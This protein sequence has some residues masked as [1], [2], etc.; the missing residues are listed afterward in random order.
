[1][2]ASLLERERSKVVSCRTYVPQINFRAL[3]PFLLLSALAACDLTK[4]NK[5]TIPAAYANHD[6]LAV[7]DSITVDEESTVEANVLAN[8]SDPD[9]SDSL[10]IESLIQPVHGIATITKANRVLYTPDALYSG[11]DSFS[12]DLSDGHGGSSTA[13]V[14]I[15]VNHRNHSPVAHND[16]SSL[17]EDGSVNINVLA[18]DT[19]VDSGDSLNVLSVG[20]PTHGIATLNI[21]NSITYTPNGGFHGEDLFNYTS[22]DDHSGSAI[23][24]VF[25]TVDHVNH[26][27]LAVADTA[28][29]NENS[30]VDVSVLANDTDVDSDTL[31]ILSID[32]QSHGVASIVNTQIH[33]VPTALYFGAATITYTIS[34]GHGGN[35]QASVAI[36]VVPDPTPPSGYAATLTS[37]SLTRK[38]TATVNIT[39]TA[40]AAYWIESP[41]QPDVSAAWQTCP[42]ATVFSGSF[43]L[44]AGMNSP[45]IWFMSHSQIVAASAITLSAV[46]KINSV[47]LV[48][49]T[50]GTGQGYNGSYPAFGTYAVALTNGNIVAGDK[51]D[52]T[53]G[54]N[55]GAWHLYNGTSGA[56]IASYYGAQANDNFGDYG[57]AALSNGNFVLQSYWADVSGVTDSG[58]VMLVNGTSGAIITSFSGNNPNDRFGYDST[59]DLMNGNFVFSSSMDTVAGKASAGSVTLVNGTTG[60][61]LNTASGSN[62]GD[63]MAISGMMING[64]YAV[65]TFNGNS[66]QTF[67]NGTTGTVQ[68][69]Y[70]GATAGDQLGLYGIY[71]L[72]NGNI[73]MLSPVATVAGHANAGSTTLLQQGTYTV[74]ATLNGSHA[75]DYF[76]SNYFDLNNGNFVLQTSYIDVGAATDAGALTL[77][78]GTTGAVISTLSGDNTNDYFGSGGFLL[79]AG[80]NFATWS[81]VDDVAG[82]IDAGSV[83]MINGT[84]GAVITTTTGATAGDKIGSNFGNSMAATLLSNG[85]FVVGSTHKTVGGFINA[86]SV[87]LLNGT[88]GD[89]VAT[90]NGTYQN[91]LLGF[92]GV[93]ALTNGNFVI[94]QEWA[95]NGAI[96]NAGSAILVNG[97]NGDTIATFRG[98]TAEDQ[99]GNDGVVDLKNGNFVISSRYVEKPGI[100]DAG[101]VTLINATSGVI[102]ST[103]VGDGWR[104]M[105]GI[106]GVYRLR[107]GNYVVSTFS[108]DN[109]GTNAGSVIL[110]NGSNGTILNTVHGDHDWDNFGYSAPVELPNGNF[111]F[112][113]K[114]DTVGGVTGVGS[115]TLMSGSTGNVLASFHGSTANDNM[116][117]YLFS[118]LPNSSFVIQS[119]SYDNHGF[120]DAGHLLLVP[121]DSD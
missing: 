46:N 73:L 20:N 2:L 43:A 86:G 77:V 111:I 116:G 61:I 59:W 114:Y 25:V 72:S 64:D 44:L 57:A 6:P 39:C 21:D 10:T 78:N 24:T 50:P 9:N 101:T 84:T 1:M 112:A 45:K 100:Q 105:M 8:D 47:E 98:D 74:I 87:M 80:G 63:A 95:S 38:S 15:I 92:S 89:I 66:S 58:I 29:V 75:D 36:T 41:A 88:T 17:N 37:P 71:E 54:S 35:S 65:G 56:I 18:N 16:S 31:S 40:T 118:I 82:K 28:S 94:R 26:N 5:D 107:N 104:D 68:A 49:P 51:R 42:I 93:T 22:G 121:G 12:Y 11:E 7:D 106:N 103:I 34:D 109:G 119:P 115:V 55:S 83:V 110:V 52:S 97:V 70:T 62:A 90:L 53:H 30:S 91:N 117:E 3:V 120:V 48:D 81:E 99:F 96:H 102:V 60:A 23:A 69:T 13:E 79:L 27:P 14:S 113:A 85:N 67:I 76:G 32:A 4:F 19:D 33:F 108:D